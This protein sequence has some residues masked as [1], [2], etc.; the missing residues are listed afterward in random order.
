MW[1]GGA[2][3]GAFTTSSRTCRHVDRRSQ[4]RGLYHLLKDMTCRHVDRRSQYRGL[5]HLLKD[6]LTCGQEEP[7]Q[8]PLR[9]PQ[10]H[11]DMWTGGASTGAFTSS[12]RTCRH[13][14]RRSQYRGLYH[15]LKD[16]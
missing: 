3:T 11:V 10:G 9:P 5:Y 14:D 13:V 16:M 6:M 7:V 15:L 2:S 1:T 12:S 8:G 4:Y